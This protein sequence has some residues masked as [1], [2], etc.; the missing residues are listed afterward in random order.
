MQISLFGLNTNIVE[1]YYNIS[2]NN[3]TKQRG[4]QNWEMI[5][6]NN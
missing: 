5:F 6:R 3:F 1:N 4:H 2:A